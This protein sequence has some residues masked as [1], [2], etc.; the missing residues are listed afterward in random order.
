MTFHDHTSRDDDDNDD[1]QIDEQAIGAS[2]DDLLEE[3][4]SERA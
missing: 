2:T 3:H 4:I 1:A